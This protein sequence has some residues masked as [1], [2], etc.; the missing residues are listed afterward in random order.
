MELSSPRSSL[1]TKNL[2]VWFWTYSLRIVKDIL[3]SIGKYFK[4]VSHPQQKDFSNSWL[5]LDI[6]IINY[7]LFLLSL[8]GFI[9][10]TGEA[11]GFL[12][13]YFDCEAKLLRSL[14][15]WS[16]KTTQYWNISYSH[17]VHNLC[18]ILLEHHTFKHIQNASH[19]S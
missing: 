8:R 16:A 6:L 14:H 18:Y 9:L 5:L 17:K 10:F 19:N 12:G 4:L 3:F 15:T 2:G 13:N 1:A 7:W 11:R